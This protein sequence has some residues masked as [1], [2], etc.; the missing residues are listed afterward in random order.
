MVNRKF[1]GGVFVLIG[2]VLIGVNTFSLTGFAVSEGN[3]FRMGT[4]VL[5]FLKSCI[6]HIIPFYQFLLNFSKTNDLK[7]RFVLVF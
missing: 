1:V 4:N 7:T 2:L 5:G 3:L 6:F